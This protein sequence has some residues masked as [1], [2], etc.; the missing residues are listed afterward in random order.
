[1]MGFDPMRI[2]YIA[3]ATER[4]LGQGN[5]R[6][7]EVVGMRQVAEEHWG[8]QVGVNLG[9]GVGMLLWRSPLRVF[10]RPFFHTPLV[11]LFIFASEV[12]HDRVWYPLKGRRVVEQW[13]RESPWGRL[14]ET[15]PER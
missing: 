14:F 15:Y 9:T 13:K 12:Y 11:N 3:H 2:P 1:M 8:F 7:I 5:P 6:E 10:Q 4:G